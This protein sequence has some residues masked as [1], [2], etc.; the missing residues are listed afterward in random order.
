MRTNSSSI[1]TRLVLILAAAF[2]LSGCSFISLQNV[3]DTTATISVRTPDSGKAYTRTIRS[4]DSVDVFSSYGGRYTVTTIPSERYRQL[5]STL[6][7]AIT[8]RLFEEAA[9]LTAEGVSVLT[10]NLNQIDR[11]IEGLD[12]PG[13]TCSGNVADFDTSVVIISYDNNTGLWNLSCGSTN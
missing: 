9:T 6:Q 8:T 5:L 2:I 13:A 1:L 3:A 12:E 10:N 7:Q 11:M 4:R